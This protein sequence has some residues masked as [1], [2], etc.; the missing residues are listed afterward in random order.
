ML[1]LAATYRSGHLSW[2]IEKD[3][4][5]SLLNRTINFLMSQAP[6]STTLFTD[7]TLLK[8]IKDKIEGT[9]KSSVEVPQ[10][11]SSFGSMLSH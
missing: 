4:L 3:D 5:L 11:T 2:L 8:H 7:A 9:A 10:P 1:V 6:V